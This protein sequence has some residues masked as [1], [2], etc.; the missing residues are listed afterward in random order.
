MLLWR[1][2]P[3]RLEA[4]AIRDAMLSVSGLLDATQ[5]GPGTLDQH[6]NRRSV[7]FFINE[8]AHSNDDAL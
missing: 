5:F 3:R 7:Y 1:R 2:E 4:E 6:T 8:P